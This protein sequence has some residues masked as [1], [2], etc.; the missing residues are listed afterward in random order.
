M[1]LIADSG[2]TK[3]EWCVIDR[4]KQ[5]R[6]VFT[7]GINPYFQT[8]EEI[9][10]EVEASLV[11][12]IDD[13]Y[14]E[15]VWFYGAGC[16][17]DE[18][19]QIIE[20]ALLSIKPSSIKIDSDLTGAARAL[21]RRQ[22]GIAC[23]LGTGSNSC[24]Y[25]GQAVAQNVSPL[26][27]ILGDEGSGAVLGKALASDCLKKQLPKPLADKFM[28]RYGLTTA[29]ILEHVY[30]QPFP[31]RYLA[32]FSPFLIE[33]IS[34]PAIYELVYQSFRSFF[35]RNVM[36]YDGF[37]AYPVSFTGSIAF[38]FQSVLIR[39]ARSLSVNIRNIEQTPMPGLIAYHS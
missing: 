18:K 30:R 32:S 11:P 20:G 33:N 1:K 39:A 25:D 26:G 29:G 2:S 31:N 3:T 16:T 22:P 35:V 7:K 34:E 12:L 4:G 37:E 8:G 38:F 10:K 24:L 28:E 6:Q 21:C 14:I 9:R 36:Q 19:K 27:Y 5:V 13:L 15:E 17:S 23:I